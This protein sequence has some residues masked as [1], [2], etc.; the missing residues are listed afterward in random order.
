M[1]ACA[2]WRTGLDSE[3]SPGLHWY[4]VFWFFALS[5]LLCDHQPSDLTCADESATGWLSVFSSDTRCVNHKGRPAA[6]IL[7]Y[8]PYLNWEHY[9]NC[10]AQHGYDR[11]D[12]N[13]SLWVTFL[14]QCVIG[15]QLIPQGLVALDCL[16]KPFQVHV[17]AVCV[18]VL[19]PTK[20]GA[21]THCSTVG[22]KLYW[23]PRQT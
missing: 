13:L 2:P 15:R 17:V 1:S 19:C 5:S 11:E 9:S 22:E 12:R 10:H 21:H 7:A 8:R 18:R 3:S 20:A 4:S 14:S 23:S 16:I 6:Y